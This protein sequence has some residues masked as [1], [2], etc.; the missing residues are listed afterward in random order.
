MSEAKNKNSLR[1]NKFRLI[2]VIS[3]VTQF[4]GKS[5]RLQDK[6]CGLISLFLFLLWKAYLFFC[7]NKSERSLRFQRKM[8]KKSSFLLFDWTRSVPPRYVSR[9]NRENDFRYDAAFIIL[10]KIARHCPIK[11]TFWGKVQNGK[12]VQI[13]DDFTRF[14]YF[15]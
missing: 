12:G 9:K 4:L 6:H 11:T 5:M 2:S 8:I 15:H 3:R 13:I 10:P 14:Y 1:D 7:L